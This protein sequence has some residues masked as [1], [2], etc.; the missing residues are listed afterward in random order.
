MQKSES[1]VNLQPQVLATESDMPE[2]TEEKP[3]VSKVDPETLK[4]RMEEDKE[5]NA[6]NEEKD[7]I[8]GLIEEYKDAYYDEEEFRKEAYNMIQCHDP[9]KYRKRIVGFISPFGTT[10]KD[11]RVNK[12]EKSKRYKFKSKEDKELIKARVKEIK[13]L[14]ENEKKKKEQE[15][16]ELYQKNRNLMKNLH[17]KLLKDKDG[18]IKEGAIPAFQARSE[19]QAF[20]VSRSKPV[21]KLNQISPSRINIAPGTK[22]SIKLPN[23]FTLESLG[24]FKLED[25]AEDGEDQLNLAEIVDENNDGSDDEI[26]RRYKKEERKISTNQVPK[27]PL[28]TQDKEEYQPPNQN[29][30]KNKGVTQRE[31]DVIKE[32]VQKQRVSNNSAVNNVVASIPKTLSKKELISYSNSKSKQNLLAKSHEVSSII[33]K[34][35]PT[36]DDEKIYKNKLANKGRKIELSSDARHSEKKNYGNPS[37]S[38]PRNNNLSYI[39]K[40]V[41]RDSTKISLAM[42]IADQKRR[43]FILN[44]FIAS[45]K[46]KFSSIKANNSGMINHKVLN[47]ITIDTYDRAN[48]LETKAKRNQEERLQNILKMHDNNMKRGVG[49]ANKGR[50]L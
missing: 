6:L 35:G 4:K 50:I 30:I 36:S 33:K 38:P 17:Y 26:L 5:I 29:K 10:D 44:L 13:T 41:K 8:I 19:E 18:N 25:L 15:K 3:I 22:P 23:K 40:S 11:E 39:P 21:L 27:S 32:Q 43:L 48:K 37:Q 28:R 34:K 20:D 9:H 1:E 31:K 47:N 42:A 46:G 49:I 7:R 14:R 24:Q 2:I 12:E 45:N 16:E